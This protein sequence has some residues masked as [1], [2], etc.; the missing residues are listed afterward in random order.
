MKALVIALLAL[1]ALPAAAAAHAGETAGTDY[2]TDILAVPAGVEA[3]IVGG[4]DRMVLTRTTADEVVVLGYGGEPYLRLDDEGVWEN[5]NSPAVALNA[6]RQPT[7]PLE[8]ADAAPDWVRVG[9][10]ASAVFHDHRSHWMGSTAPAAVLADPDRAQRLFDWEVPLEVDGRAVA[11]TGDVT[12]L[13]RPAAALWWLA[14]ALAA[15]AG[16]AV[17]LVATGRAIPVA[18]LGAALAIGSGTAIGL[19]AQ[20]DLPE[21]GGGALVAVAVALVLGGAAAVGAYL[22]RREPAHAATVLLLAAV[23][24]GAIQLLDSAGPA[25][26]YALVPGPLPTLAVRVLIVLGVAGT[27]LAAGACAR[28]WRDLLQPHAAAGTRTAK[29][30]AW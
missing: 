7:A 5:R 26:S 20:L 10:G 9:T 29:G 21:G 1:L 3:R 11:I 2:R 8:G 4:D 13:G 6:E 18:A 16:L 23:I 14:A 27:M 30:G 12:W 15:A 24:A 19:S 28:A 17:G 25:F 22:T